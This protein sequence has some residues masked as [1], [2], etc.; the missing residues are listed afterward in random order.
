MLQQLIDKTD[1]ILNKVVNNI[2]AL[3]NSR[4]IAQKYLEKLKVVFIWV[5]LFCKK[6]HAALN[7][8]IVI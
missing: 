6:H 3:H 2:W 1:R 8:T 4:N 7:K 5:G